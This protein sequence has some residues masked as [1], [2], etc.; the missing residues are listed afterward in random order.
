MTTQEYRPVIAQ[1]KINPDEVQKLENQLEDVQEK[2]NPKESQCI[3]LSNYCIIQGKFKR[4]TIITC[5]TPKE[6]IDYGIDT[7]PEHLKETMQKLQYDLKLNKKQIDEVKKSLKKLDLNVTEIEDQYKH[8]LNAA[9]KAR[10]RN[11]KQR[12]L[13]SFNTRYSSFNE[14][15]ISNLATLDDKDKIYVRKKLDTLVLVFDD[16]K[17]N[18]L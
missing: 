14:C 1:E 10:E 13:N 15:L 8:L 11:E 16:V 18:Y 9:Q 12:I 4:D 17:Q 6:P 3:M 5:K 7:F 2:V